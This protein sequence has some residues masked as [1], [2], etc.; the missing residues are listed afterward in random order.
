[1]PKGTAETAME[2]QPL[3][4]EPPTTDKSDSY[5]ALDRWFAAHG[6]S[7]Q[8]HWTARE[9]LFRAEVP[10]G[11]LG[12]VDRSNGRLQLHGADCQVEELDG[13]QCLNARLGLAPP[14][15]PPYRLHVA[16]FLLTCLTTVTCGATGI[17]DPT[18]IAQVFGLLVSACFE[19]FYGVQGRA[20]PIPSP[21][22]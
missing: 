1:M 19:R 17:G 15:R 9:V 21:W 22:F 6:R 2:T 10:P 4:S 8:V 12:E 14:Y 20:F 7:Y 18:S 5:L 3:A 11:V 16:L 13:R